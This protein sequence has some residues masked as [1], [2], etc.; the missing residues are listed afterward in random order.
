LSQT[1]EQSRKSVQELWHYRRQFL[2]SDSPFRPNE[3]WSG[4][5][6]PQGLYLS[7][8]ADLPFVQKAQGEKILVVLGI[9]VD[10]HHPEDGED[11]VLETLW[12]HF[13][14][15]D[16]LIEGARFAAGRWVI[17]AFDGEKSCIFTDPCGF[18]TVFYGR[19]EN[20]IFCASQPGLIHEQIELCPDVDP[21]KLE[22]LR[23]NLYLSGENTWIGTE[24]PYLGVFHLLPNHFLDLNEARQTRFY[25]KKQV[26]KV[27]TLDEVVEKACSILQG[28]IKALTLRDKLALP[29]TSGFDSRVL[30]AASKNVLSDCHCYIYG[31][32][33]LHEEHP[34]IL[35]PKKMSERFGFP[36]EIVYADFQVPDWFGNMLSS[37]VT[38]SR[39]LP[40]TSIIY[41][42]LMSGDERVN[43][44]GNGSEI[45]RNYFDHYGRRSKGKLNSPVLSRLILGSGRKPKYIIKKLTEWMNDLGELTTGSFNL[46]DYLYWEQRL[47]NWGAQFPSEQDVAREEISPFNCRELLEILVAAPRRYRIAPSYKLYRKLIQRMWPELLD[48]PFNPHLSSKISSLKQML[49]KALPSSA[50]NNIRRWF[51]A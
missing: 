38:N 6:L 35:I 21:E 45:C 4:V 2:L 37:N 29:I 1:V 28:T 50:E 20:R 9:L 40:K 17:L 5:Y 22:Y 27:L 26:L 7:V 47:G 41:H 10:P 25:P 18:R 43:I 12:S 11:A 8:H 36:F 16:E 32:K 24:T 14:G 19:L 34:D 3:C 49:R 30:L 48:Y 13:T 51:R 23:S 42:Q 33:S 44:N 39:N 31:L 15:F 46:L